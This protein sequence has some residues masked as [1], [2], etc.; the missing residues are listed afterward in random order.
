MKPP[1][2]RRLE[3]PKVNNGPHRLFAPCETM[4][5]PAGGIVA[6]VL[7]Q[8]IHGPFLSN[9]AFLPV[10]RSQSCVSQ[11]GLSPAAFQVPPTRNLLCCLR[12]RLPASIKNK[13]GGSKPPRG[14]QGDRKST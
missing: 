10:A 13:N 4:I 8:P 11:A 3:K 7:D 1:P 5:R 14:G 6:C 2:D 12:Q 9:R